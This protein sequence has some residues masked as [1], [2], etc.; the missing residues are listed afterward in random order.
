MYTLA[1]IGSFRKHYDEIRELIEFFAN[2][3]ILVTS[4]KYSTISHSRD[5][6]VVFESDNNNLTNAEIQLVTLGNILSA[7]VVYVYNP[8]GY[9][10][11]TTSYEIGI[12]TTMHK[13]IYY[14]SE[15]VDLP[16]V[17]VK[18]QIIDPTEIS[19]DFEKYRDMNHLFELQY[20]AKK[21]FNDYFA[22]KEEIIKSIATK[23]VI[24]GSMTF[25]DE[26]EELQHE[27][28]RKG[29]DCIIPAQENHLIDGF[30]EDQMNEFKKKVSNSYLAK[31]RNKNTEAILV[32]NQKKRGID[33]YIGPNTLVEIAMAFTW[34]RKI[35]LYFDLY[36][37][38]IDE[39]K[40]WDVIPLNGNLDLLGK[41]N[42][43]NSTNNGGSN[44]KQVSLFD[45]REQ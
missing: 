29:I 2:N 20:E 4:P 8:H 21:V 19:K 39:L 42:I 34:Y 26:M 28:L 43:D 17:F 37:P 23:I 7:N 18:Q 31:I 22:K 33:N 16:V 25:Y 41:E 36:E 12:C 45:W 5:D 13:K 14:F 40:A 24:C 30:T 11:K 35:Y 9:I 15:P 27:L 6:F 1:I 10:G 3:G 44:G 32:Y 38:F